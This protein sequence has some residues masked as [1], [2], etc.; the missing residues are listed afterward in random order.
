M[1]SIHRQRSRFDKPHFS[2]HG[3]TPVCR[4]SDLQRLHFYEIVPQFL[5]AILTSLLKTLKEIFMLLLPDNW[6][7]VT[8]SVLGWSHSERSRSSSNREETA[9]WHHSSLLP[10]TG[11]FSSSG[12]SLRLYYLFLGA[13]ILWHHLSYQC[14]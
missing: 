5:N 3:N 12:S 14:F 7:I 6:I 13:L 1:N 2:L 10:L 11:F 4:W 9:L 8:L